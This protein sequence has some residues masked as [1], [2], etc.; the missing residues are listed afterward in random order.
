MRDISALKKE[1]A[2]KTEKAGILE[3]KSE[4]IYNALNEYT[5]NMEYQRE[6]RRSEGYHYESVRTLH[7]VKL[8][9]EIL[10][11]Q[12]KIKQM[13]NQAKKESEAGQMEDT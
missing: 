3:E 6:K 10:S 8:L 12:E 1:I 5:D 9:K 11:L 7:E 13:Q 2:E 4:R